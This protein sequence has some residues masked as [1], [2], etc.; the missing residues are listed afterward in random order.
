[1]WRALNRVG[2]VRV[3]RILA[4]PSDGVRVFSTVSAQSA[5]LILHQKPR[6]SVTAGHFAHND[7]GFERNDPYLVFFSSFHKEW[8]LSEHDSCARHSTSSHQDLRPPIALSLGQRGRR[9]GTAA[10]AAFGVIGIPQY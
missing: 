9:A 5:A 8:R 10:A 3:N 6:R 2:L 1:M 4:R 7:I